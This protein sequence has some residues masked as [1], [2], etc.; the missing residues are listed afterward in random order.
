MLARQKKYK[1]A[2]QHELTARMFQLSLPLHVLLSEEL[3]Q[4]LENPSDLGL[5]DLRHCKDLTEG[6][7]H[8]HL[9]ARNEQASSYD[10]F[11]RFT[12]EYPSIMDLLE[13]LLCIVRDV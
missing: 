5:G 10:R 3:L 13:Q 11:L 8:S 1:P 12:P 6:S 9:P 4:D 2:Q 7:R